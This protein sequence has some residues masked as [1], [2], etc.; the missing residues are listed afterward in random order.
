[1]VLL[2]EISCLCEEV[3][4]TKLQNGIPSERV[5]FSLEYNVPMLYS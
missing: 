1:M 3:R 5:L 2:I 4:A